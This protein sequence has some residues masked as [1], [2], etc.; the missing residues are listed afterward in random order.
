VEAHALEFIPVVSPL[1][2]VSQ[3]IFSVVAAELF[4]MGIVY[5]HLIACCVAIGLVLTSD[6]T[7][8]AHMLKGNARQDPE[9]LRVLQKTVSIALATLW[10][11]GIA[12]VVR[13]AQLSGWDYLL[14]PKIQAKIVIVC[15]LTLNGV[16][17]HNA[18]LPALARAGGLLELSAA[19]RVLAVFAGSVS[20]VSWFYAAMLGI[21]RPLNWKYSL[22]ELLAM[23]PA[24]IAAAF[25]AM[26]ALTV[27]ARHRSL[28]FRLSGP[29]LY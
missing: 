21:G 5:V 24:F 16:L 28:N 25:L 29:I 17:L 3:A 8:V 27:W 23:Y 11:T 14:N 1:L 19:R 15:L 6:M 12:L 2:S 20:A 7:F 18:V 26:L 9:H 10:I 22:A 13:D 4:R